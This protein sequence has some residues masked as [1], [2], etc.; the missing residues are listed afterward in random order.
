MEVD[1]TPSNKKAKASNGKTKAKS[2]VVASRNKKKS[3]ASEDERTMCDD[4]S[5]AS[6][7]SESEIDEYDDDDDGNVSN[8]VRAEPMPAA[9]MI[10][11]ISVPQAKTP[12]R[13]AAPLKKEKKAAKSLS[14]NS[15]T[16]LTL[17]FLKDE[18]RR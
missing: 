5:D 8:Q 10:S 18:K 15:F 7:Q 12:Q 13:R 6:E 16:H 17:E 3:E 4:G 2:S 9:I 11:A 14:D 1:V